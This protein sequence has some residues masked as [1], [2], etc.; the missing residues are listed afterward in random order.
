MAIYIALL[1]GI[2]VGGK[3]LI[4]MAELK[5][6]FEAMGLSRVRTYIQSG[7]VLFESEE[8]EEPLRVRIEHEV[9]AAHGFFVNVVL[10]N[11]EELRRIAASCPFSEE[12]LSR[13]GASAEGESLYVAFLL[14]EASQESV[15]CLAPYKSEDE[16]YRASGREIFLLFGKS[17][18]NSRLA[19]NL[20]R[21]DVPV[22]VRNW[23]TLNKLVALASELEG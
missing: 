5:R 1:R 11:A 17:V 23:K 13:A 18:R 7:N 20:Q 3:N 22:T 14:R 2:N 15:E 12:E 6:T 16:Q 10:R 8:E 9:E 19:A 21:L 4:K